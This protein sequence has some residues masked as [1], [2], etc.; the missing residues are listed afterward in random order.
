MKKNNQSNKISTKKKSEVKKSKNLFDHLN[1]IRTTKDPNY[2]ISLSEREQKG[3]NHWSILNALSMDNNLI[4]LVAFLWQ[5]GYYDVIPSPQFY[6]LLVEL[7]PQTS[8]RLFWIKKTRKRNQKLL[9][10]IAEWFNISTREADEYLDI[11]MMN[12][13]GNK[14][15]GNILEGFG[16]TDTEAEKVLE[17]DTYDE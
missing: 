6:Q 16:L 11:F 12:D 14:E 5:D 7:V 4:D 3:F 10:Y 2:Y 8:Q 1:A 17:G 13:D 15:I 9:K